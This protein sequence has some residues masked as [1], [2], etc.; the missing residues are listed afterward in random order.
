MFDVY[1]SRVC[2]LVSP[3]LKTS[4]DKKTHVGFSGRVIPETALADVGVLLVS[5]E[6]G[7][8]SASG[9]CCRPSPPWIPM[10]A[11]LGSYRLFACLLCLRCF[12][13]LALLAGFDNKL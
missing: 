10:V 3:A 12:A 4:R 9:P 5:S 7:G 1:A 8:C 6:F 13:L 2:N 11:A